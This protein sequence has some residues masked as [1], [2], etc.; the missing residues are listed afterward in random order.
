MPGALAK[1]VRSL[2]PLLSFCFCSAHI[3]CGQ[4]RSDLRLLQGIQP[5]FGVCLH[6]ADV[7]IRK[8]HS[9]RDGWHTVALDII[10]RMPLSVSGRQSSSTSAATISA[11]CWF[12]RC[13]SARSSPSMSA[14]SSL[15]L[16][17]LLALRSVP[18]ALIWG[19]AMQV[20]ASR[21]CAMRCCVLLMSDAAERHRRRMSIAFIR[22]TSKS[23][24]VGAFLSYRTISSSCS[25]GRLLKN[26]TSSALTSM[27]A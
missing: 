22:V 26:S 13:S 7:P 16:S 20:S 17:L 5:A 8:A 1:G 12:R 18:S 9:R 11:C 15:V 6:L 4:C 3:P 24:H 19:A 23:V 14:I 27:L 2:A 25:A 21:R 10:A